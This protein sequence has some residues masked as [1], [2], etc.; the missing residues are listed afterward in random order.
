V[1]AVDGQFT[2]GD[3]V[4]VCDADGA[5]FARGLTN[6]TSAEIDRIKG[7]KTH[8]ILQVLGYHPYDE[9]VHRDNMAVTSSGA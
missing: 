8:Q 3:V 6:Y 7:L 1:T 2:K 9:I 5:E 4:S